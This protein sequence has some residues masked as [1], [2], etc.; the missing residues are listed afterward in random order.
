MLPAVSAEDCLFA[1]LGIDPSY[2]GL[3][4][5]EAT[6]ML[7]RRRKLLTD[8]H[9]IIA[10][11]GDLVFSRQGH[12]N[13]NYRV[14]IEHLQSQYGENYTITHYIGAQFP[15]CSPLIEYHP[16]S[17]F[18]ETEVAKRITGISTFYIP[19]KEVH[20]VD[21][22]MVITLGLVPTEKEATNF[23]NNTVR[24][25]AEYGPQEIKAIE[26]LEEWTVPYEYAHTPPTKAARYIGSLATNI[27]LLRR[28]MKE[29]EQSMKEF[30]LGP[31]EIEALQSNHSGRICMTLK[32]SADDVAKQVVIRMV[33]DSG[34]ASEFAREARKIEADK[35]SIG[36][37]EEW[38]SMQGCDTTLDAMSSAR[39]ELQES[40]LLMWSGMYPSTIA[41]A[42][43]QIQGE[44]PPSTGKVWAAGV[45]VKKPTFS[46]YTLSWSSSDGNSHSASLV[47]KTNG[48]HTLSFTGRFWKAG[49]P[50]PILD[51][52]QGQN[53]PFKSSLANWVGRYKTTL[54][55]VTGPEVVVAI[56]ES[57][58]TTTSEPSLSIEVGRKAISCFTYASNKKLLAWTDQ[59]NATNASFTFFERESVGINTF[60]FSG[61]YWV[62]GTMP[63]VEDNFSGSMDGGSPW[64][65]QDKGNTLA[66][67]LLT[68]R[69][70][71]AVK[72][73]GVAI[74]KYFKNPTPENKEEMEQAQREAEEI[75]EEQTAVEN[76]ITEG[77]LPLD[78][79][80]P[81]PGQPS[82]TTNTTQTTETDT[83]YSA[84]D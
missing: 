78:P 73:L 19:P 49:D 56:A 68:M 60:H 4:I 45:L 10:C 21:P 64:S 52:I 44:S 42:T 69:L 3:Q 81:S 24:P 59:N 71:E 61:K 50:E 53:G 36:A 83:T 47:F 65:V 35:N 9:V 38:L 33:T 6:D 7:L 82:V 63:P 70:V 11:V 37:I 20:E 2:P 48:K 29:P 58:P 80:E 46:N 55:E 76:S 17:E 57:S 41:N 13:H 43:F 18:L 40:S 23:P 54:Q 75:G 12:L 62:K 74:L 1:D 77:Y 79:V 84:E 72:F 15:I 14:L 27:K 32:S 5:L 51:N 25:V 28:H 16:L 26:Q 22:K 67:G 30:Q 34:F 8:F 66:M 31:H 39:S